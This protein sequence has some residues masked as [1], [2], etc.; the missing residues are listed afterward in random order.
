MNNLTKNLTRSD[1]LADIN[2]LGE[3]HKEVVEDI[4]L[5][6]DTIRERAIYDH[7]NHFIDGFPAVLTHENYVKANSVQKS[8][9]YDVVFAKKFLFNKSDYLAKAGQN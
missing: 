2:E 6:R 9:D 3:A 4:K 7:K 8:E 5:T 1:I